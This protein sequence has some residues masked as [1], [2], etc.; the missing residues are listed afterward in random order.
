MIAHTS[1][2]ISIAQIRQGEPGRKKVLETNQ[3]VKRTEKGIGGWGKRMRDKSIW[4]VM[5]PIRRLYWTEEEAKR[6]RKGKQQRGKRAGW[7]SKSV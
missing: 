5:N 1:F 7:N 3:A 2:A 6:K 4:H